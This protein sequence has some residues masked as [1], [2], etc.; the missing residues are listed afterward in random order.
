MYKRVSGTKD[1]LPDE[2]ICWQ[3]IEEISRRIFS[4]YNYQEIRP[5]I[6]E[7]AGL[8]NRSLGEFTEIVQKQMFLIKN[9]ED[10]YAL[11][12]EGTASIVRCFIENNLDKTNGFV[13]LYYMG[14]MFRLER[15][16][17]GRLRQFHHIGTE[18]IGSTAPEVD[19]E[20]ISLADE[21]LKA[22]SISGY[23][24]KINSIGCS[25]DKKALISTINKK[26]EGEL[27]NLCADCNERFK[28]NVLRILDCK[29]EACQAV[30]NK[31]GVAHE[32]LCPDCLKHFSAV[33][34]GLDTL[35]IEYE[36]SPLLVRGLDYYTSTVFEI[37][38]PD[39]GAQD[40]VGAGGRY[41]NLVK[42]LG[43]PQLGAVGFAFGVERLLLVTKIQEHID[44]SKNLVYVISLGDE[45]RKEGLKLLNS[46][47]KEGIPSST[48]YEIMSLKGAMRS[49]NDAAAKFVVI[50]GEDELKKN[51]VMLKNMQTSEQKEITQKDLI[52][53]LKC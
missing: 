29:N 38:H 13:K 19:I 14:P 48:D 18:V 33:K 49:A 10:T 4:L 50:I 32:H 41:D 37:K 27:E 43:G 28:H 52:K 47:R 16:Q 7:D 46:L 42:E 35:K 5:P 17:K 51:V 12:P 11:R 30:I 25:K 45:A 24:I 6:I 39:L 40:A 1:I 53:E 22:Y 20:V 36:V 3:K 21:L 34:Q 2:V 9:L 23:K 44:T 15:P 26:L 8:F 31:I